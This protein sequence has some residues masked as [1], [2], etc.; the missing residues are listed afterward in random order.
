MSD[1]ITVDISAEA[2]VYYRR[3]VRMK[4]EDYVRYLS[5]C[6]YGGE[7]AEIYEI[8]EKYHF[9]ADCEDIVRIDEPED[10]EFSEVSLSVNSDE[11]K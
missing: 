3:R 5:I 1:L 9:F 7:D 8:A 10:I 2:K 6:D 4:Q 11:E